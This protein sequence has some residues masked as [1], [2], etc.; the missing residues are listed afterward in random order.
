MKIKDL[1][2][3]PKEELTELLAST[4]KKIAEIKFNHARARSKNVKEI[5]EL[6]RGVARVM[7]LLREKQP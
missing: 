7:T 2:L 1:R 4:K 6:K 5:R 3:K